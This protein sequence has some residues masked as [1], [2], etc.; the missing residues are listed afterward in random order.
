M[1]EAPKTPVLYLLLCAAPPARDMHTFIPD[2][3]TAGWDVCVIATPQ[4]TRWIEIPNLETITG[5][6]VR[7]EETIPKRG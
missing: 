5:H 7:T 6:P 3:R 4:A 2:L 1:S